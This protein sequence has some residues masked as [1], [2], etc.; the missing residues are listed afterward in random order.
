MNKKSLLAGIFIVVFS[1]LII[2][3]NKEPTIYFRLVWIV[4]FSTGI[5]LTT[6]QFRESLAKKSIIISI[7]VNIISLIVLVF[8]IAIFKTY[9]LI[10]LIGIIVT[11][12]N[13]L[14]GGYLKRNE[15]LKN[16][17]RYK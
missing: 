9:P 3:L 13:I 14:Y 10:V 16:M 8:Y 2:F 4:L 12:F 6:S 17:N 15:N 7:L 1:L 11:I 5:S